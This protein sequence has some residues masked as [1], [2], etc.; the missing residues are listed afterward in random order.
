MKV[1]LALEPALVPG[2]AAVLAADQSEGIYQPRVWRRV[3]AAVEKLPGGGKTHVIV[4]GTRG[5]R[6]SAVAVDCE[7]VVAGNEYLP[8]VGAI[9]QTVNVMQR[10]GL[11]I[12]ARGKKRMR[13]NGNDSR[14]DQHG[15][16]LHHFPPCR[17]NVPVVP[18]MRT[19]LTR[20]N[21]NM[22]ISQTSR[23]AARATTRSG[24]YATRVEIRYGRRG[25]GST[26]V[27]PFLVPVK[28]REW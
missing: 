3:S 15:F 13:K 26:A 17:V 5:H 10:D 27:A 24:P 6:P 8:A 4:R 1:R 7:S 21:N 14:C 19:K 25:S 22:K 11:G 16:V 9:R 20:K 23:N 12:S 2:L 18:R 28:Q